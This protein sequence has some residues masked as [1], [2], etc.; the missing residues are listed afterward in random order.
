LQK[1][2]PMRIVLLALFIILSFSTYSQERLIQANGQQ[3]NVLTKGLESRKVGTPIIIF[4]NGMG[5]G[6]G[7]WNTVMDELAEELPILAY[8]RAGVNKSEKV[9]KMPTIK[10]VAENLKAILAALNIP[11]P[12]LLVGHSLG[13]VYIRGFAGF[14][15]N[16]IAGLV[17]IDPADFTESKNDWNNIFRTL[18]LSEQRIDE[19]LQNRLYRPISIDSSRFGPSSEG[20]VLNELRKTDFAEISQLPFP[21]VPTYFFV[22]GKFEVPVERRSKEYDQERFFHIKNNSNMDRWKK[23]I[24]ATNKPGALIYLTHTGHY[25]HRDDPRAVIENIKVLIRS[26]EQR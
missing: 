1:I 23:L 2:K 6:L 26:L 14:Y 21:Q 10:V 7:N 12:Y 18:G 5:M 13:G 19:M 22:G 9:Y 11:P 15:P 16:D 20:A 3:F 4:E 24:Y 25:I 17:F 8:D